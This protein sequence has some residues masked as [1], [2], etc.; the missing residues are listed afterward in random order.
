MKVDK[1]CHH[2]AKRALDA[3]WMW[4]LVLGS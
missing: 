2:I 3:G 1:A 4:S